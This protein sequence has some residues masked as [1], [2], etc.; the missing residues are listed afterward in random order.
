MIESSS[1]RLGSHADNVDIP[2]QIWETLQCQ[3]SSAAEQRICNAQ[4]EVSESSSGS[5]RPEVQGNEDRKGLL[6][7]HTIP[8]NRRLAQLSLWGCY[9]SVK[10]GISVVAG[11]RDTSNVEAYMGWNPIYRSKII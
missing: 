6:T 9:K 4:V 1:N 3:I 2:V 11:A 5:N 8:P 10:R 7:M